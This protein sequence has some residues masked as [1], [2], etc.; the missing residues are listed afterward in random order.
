MARYY[1]SK[2]EHERQFR[3]LYERNFAP[4]TA[5]VQRRVRRGDGSDPD[6]VAEVFV[7]AWQTSRSETFDLRSGL[8]PQ[9]STIA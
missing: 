2:T 5:Y 9:N 4:I 7:V 1:K 6:I 3:L 8:V